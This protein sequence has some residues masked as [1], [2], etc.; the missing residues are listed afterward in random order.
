MQLWC[1]SLARPQSNGTHK[2]K[3][4]EFYFDNELKEIGSVNHETLKVS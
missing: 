1:R 4:W 3:Y 2:G